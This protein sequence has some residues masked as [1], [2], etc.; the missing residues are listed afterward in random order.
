M[1]KTVTEREFLKAMD[2]WD[3]YA[4]E[5]LYEYLIHLENEQGE[6]MQFDT[7]AFKS[8]FEYYQGDD[9]FDFMQSLDEKD[10]AEWKKDEVDENG[11]YDENSAIDFL[12]NHGVSVA[13]LD[14]NEYKLDKNYTLIIYAR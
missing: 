3:K 9:I 5:L 14:Y 1:K 10:F 2:N 6:E 8:E 12:E 11:I 7:V 4:A 13:K